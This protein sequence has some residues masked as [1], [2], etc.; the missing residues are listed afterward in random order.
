MCHNPLKKRIL[1][2]DMKEILYCLSL[3]FLTYLHADSLKNRFKQAQIGDYIVTAQESSYCLLFIRSIS[4]Q[5]LLE[6][7]CVPEKQIDLKKINWRTWITSKAPGHT[8]WHLYTIDLKTGK[9]IDCFSLS[10]KEWISLEN[11]E[12]FFAQL[13]QLELEPTPDQE[14]KRIGPKTSSESD[15]R[16]IWSPPLIQDGKKHKEPAF[17]VMHTHWPSDTSP[18]SGCRIEL[19]FDSKRPSFPFPYWIEVKSPHYAY[20]VRIVDSGHHLNLPQ[21]KVI[22]NTSHTEK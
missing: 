17:A 10:K 5:V 13:F 21:R 18:L 9:L 20:K 19:Y 3:F 11:Q 2:S 8:S 1:L 4:D 6:E 16:K 7:I 14:R 12:Q 22:N 15:Q